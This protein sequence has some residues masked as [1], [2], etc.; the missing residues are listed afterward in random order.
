VRG[1]GGGVDDKGLGIVGGGR[2][3]IRGGGG[4]RKMRGR[5]RRGSCSG[6]GRRKEGGG[7]RQGDEGGRWTGGGGNHPSGVRK[8]GARE[9][10]NS[11]AARG[12]VGGAEKGPGKE[13]LG[14]HAFRRGGDM[15]AGTRP[16]DRDVNRGAPESLPPRKK[17][18]IFRGRGNIH[19]HQGY[20]G[21]G[22][23]LRRTRRAAEIRDPGF[24]S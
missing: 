8:K 20:H 11:G 18:H 2:G 5:K 10:S 24:A 21:D 9:E 15:I 17:G 13:G 19:H 4:R 7:V 3:E 16:K 12:A 1:R 23:S 22:P 6:R 14:R